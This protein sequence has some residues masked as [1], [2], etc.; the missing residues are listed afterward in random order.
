MIGGGSWVH[1]AL[2]KPIDEELFVRM[3][4]CAAFFP[5]MQFS[6]APWE[7]VGHEN[8]DR[9]R[10]AE[11][12]HLEK[13]DMIAKLVSDAHETG[14][15][16]LR[17]LEY[18]FPH[19]GYHN[20]HDCFMLGTSILVAPVVTKGAKEKAIPLPPG[21]WEDETG[22]QF[23]GGKTVSVPVSIDSLPYFIKQG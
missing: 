2:G 9:I 23:E 22:R 5:M 1:R 16:I 18:N 13:A 15:P 4:Q 12:L 17:T 14:E 3:A 11:R 19:R 20:V 10:N 21:I 8:L 6:W 7:T